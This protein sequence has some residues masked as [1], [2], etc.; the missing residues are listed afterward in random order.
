M[1]ARMLIIED[2]ADIRFVLKTNFAKD[3]YDVQAAKD[4]ETGL[5]LA[6]KHA[7]E[8]VISDIMLPGMSGLEM[9]PELRRFS[10]AP[11]LFL[12]AKKDEVDRILGLR[13]GAADYVSKP[14]SLEEVG[15]R[16]KALL[17][18]HA[19]SAAADQAIRSG[20]VEIDLAR[21]LIAVNG[22]D[23]SLTPREFSLLKAL[24]GAD[25]RVLSRERLI[26]E[27]RGDEPDADADTRAVDQNVARLRRK[28]GAERR[29]IATVS[30][31][32]YRVILNAPPSA[33]AGRA[34]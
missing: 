8:I 11:V 10:S 9:L 2:E 29:L 1:G 33:A 14:F 28:L 23:V 24:V 22:R 25:G 20:G 18:R 32:G 7:P 30:K 6:R 4:A 15:L 26:E 3:G 17:R 13:L 21:H 16:V 27:L 5:K 34:S 19:R 12:T 31:L